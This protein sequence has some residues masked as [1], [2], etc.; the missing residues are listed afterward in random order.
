MSA[1]QLI[2]LS[3]L[4]ALSRYPQLYGRIAALG[5][6]RETLVTSR[7]G[8][9][10]E[11]PPRSGNSFFVVGF[12]MANPD[13][14]LAHH[15]H[16][17]AQVLRAIQLGVPVVTLLRNP[18][19]SALAKAAPANEPFLIGT[20]LRKFIVFWE[21]L[22]SIL[23]D[24]SPVPFEY[25]IAKPG[26]V[27]E[28]LNQ[29]YGTAFSSQ[30]PETASVFAEMES[31]R[32]LDQGPSAALRPNPNIPHLRIAEQETVLRPKAEAHPLARPALEIYRRLSAE[33][34]VS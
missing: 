33:I 7:T 28:R 32:L 11:A 30:F 8:L 34:D 24:V 6:G 29:R 23:R 1:R 2:R 31:K 4:T 25:L 17:P 22:A 21:K 20:T 3:V 27:I 10:I 12:S 19:D 16:A 9:C 14:E 13:I 15:H 5:S 26:S 18:I